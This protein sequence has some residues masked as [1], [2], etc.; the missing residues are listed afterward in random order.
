M[1]WSAL[2]FSFRSSSTLR[3]YLL[4]C[5]FLTRKSRLDCFPATFSLVASCSLI[6][7]LDF[8]PFLERGYCSS[9]ELSVDSSEHAFVLD[10]VIEPSEFIVFAFI[11]SNYAGSSSGSFIF[12]L[13]K[14]FAMTSSSGDGPSWTF[15]SWGSISFSS[16]WRAS[17]LFP[18]HFLLWYETALL[19][20]FLLFYS[21]LLHSI[22][23]PTSLL[24]WLFLVFSDKFLQ[25]SHIHGNTYIWKVSARSPWST[26]DSTRLLTSWWLP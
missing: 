1:L 17:N 21:R 24:A 23:P 20:R 9:V 8:L 11:A 22:L 5:E 16:F 2:S 3:R 4:A 18:G 14:S 6:I 19:L 25:N 15:S 26:C 7:L 13:V 12:Q 10:R